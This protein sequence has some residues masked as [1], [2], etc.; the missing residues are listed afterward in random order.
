MLVIVKTC[1]FCGRTGE[2]FLRETYGFCG[3]GEGGQVSFKFTVYCKG[4]QKCTR[5]YSWHALGCTVY[6][7]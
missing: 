7:L 1:G 4:T 2:S 6:T 5:I 3:G